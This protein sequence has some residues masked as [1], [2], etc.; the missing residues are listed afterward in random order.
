MKLRSLNFAAAVSLCFASCVYSQSTSSAIVGTVVDT[1][2]AVVPAAAVTL[3]GEGTGATR[4]ASTDNEG[5]FRFPDLIPGNYRVEIQVNGFKTQV[6]SAISLNSQE[7]RNLGNIRMEVGSVSESLSVIAESTPVQT[8][9]S[10]KAA[11]IDSTQLQNV[12]LKG[13]DVFGYMNLLPG[14]VDTAN[15]DVTSPNGLSN[16]TING[17]TSAKNFTVDGITDMDT[18][19]NATVHFEPNMDAVQELRVLTSNYQAEYG[20]NSGGTIA[21]VTKSGTKEFHGTAWWNHRHEGLNANDFFRNQRGDPLLLYRFN[22]AGWSFGGPA[23][24]PGIF[25]RNKNKFFVF[26]SQEYTRQNNGAA[27]GGG[28]PAPTQLKTVATALERTGDFSQSVDGSGNQIVVKDPTTGL[29]FSNN[30]IP[31]SR[32]SPAEAKILGI[33]PLPN[34]FPQPG[35]QDFRQYNYKDSA[36]TP[37]PRRNDVIRGDVYATTKLTGYFRWIHDYDDQQNVPFLVFPWS[38]CCLVDHPNPGHGYAASATYVFSPSMINEFTFGKSFNTWSWYSQQPAGFDRSVLGSIPFLYNHPIN[39]SDP[40]GQHSYIPVVTFGGSTPPNPANYTLGLFA[41]PDYYNANDI[42]S[43]S[44]NLTKIAGRHTMKAG[45]YFERT[46]KLQPPQGG[47][48]Y[49]GTLNFTPDPLNPLNTGSSYANA[50]LGYFNSYTEQSTRAVANY[51]IWVAEFYLQDNFRV[52]RKLTLDYG[53]RFAHHG[54]FVDQNHVIG[55]FSAGSFDPSK[56][57]RI[58]LPACKIAFTGTCPSASR[59]AVDPLTNARAPQTYVG[60]YVPGSGN[61][62]N[63][64]YTPGTGGRSDSPYEQTYLALAPRIGFAYDVFGNGKMAVRGGFGIFRNQLDGGT[65]GLNSAQGAP[66]VGFT[67]QVSYSDLSGLVPGSGVNAPVSVSSISSHLPWDMVRNASLGVQS[68]TPGGF[69]VEAS[70]VGNFGNHL[71]LTVNLNPVP[72]GANFN[73]ANI[74]PVT[75]GALT[76][77]GSVLERKTFAGLLNVNDVE[78]L[79]HTN[80]NA[81]QVAANRR[82]TRGLQFG[83]AY[84]WSHSLGAT[85]YDPLVANNDSRNYGPT[86][87]DRRHVVAINYVYEIPRLGAKL[88]N[89]VLGLVTDQWTLSGVTTVST[90]AP[91]QPTCA[92]TNGLDIT[93]STNETARCQVLGDSKANVPAGQLFN[94]AAFGLAPV[95]SIGNLGVN[96]ITGPGYQNWDATLTKTIPVGLGERRGLKLGF[97]AYNVFNHT[98]FATYGIAATYNPATSQQTTGSF[99]LPTGVRPARILALSVRFEY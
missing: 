75:G 27:T 88:G 28:I 90:G 3:T 67:S 80:Y 45:I 40:N 44:D 52:S 35:N 5:L 19:G 98:Q 41:S 87:A 22:V 37:H 74:S 93:G 77:N 69:V 9:S 26:A 89:R 99:G 68:A 85:V 55:V 21:L 16:I 38:S 13:R 6:V 60:A 30:V 20:R 84:T 86:A 70:W 81:L 18:G 14:V 76:Q 66:P 95:G 24:V 61:A 57:P 51:G 39:N 1:A 33:M 12:T 91:V 63:G 46:F 72:L 4:T 71:P 54:P 47:A 59:E 94:P 56:A 53:V 43:Y 2:N 92:A 83:L 7:T 8:A 50:L 25:N 78:F 62:A 11:L 34:Y 65:L 96:P 15:R 10:E 64:L 31:S 82:F 73:P 48:T 29:Q 32:I 97:Q 42:W 79:G 36:T 17:N 49:A 58:Y 23:Y